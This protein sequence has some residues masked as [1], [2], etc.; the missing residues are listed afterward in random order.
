VTDETSPGIFVLAGPNGGGKS[1]VGGELVRASGGQFFNPDLAALMLREADP[2]LS[3]EEANSLAWREMV[4]LLQVAIDENRSFVFETTL[5][6]STIPQLLWDAAASGIEVRI[7]FVAL[8]SAELHVERV[9]QRVLG[10]GHDI[11]ELRIRDRYD[12]SR[13]HLTDLL[14]VVKEVR[15]FDNSKPR[16]QGYEV[17]EPTMLLHM[18]DR[19]IVWAVALP[20]V[21]DWARPILTAAFE[22][23]AETAGL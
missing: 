2:E 21:P 3:E 13:V 19:Q 14:Q 12:S 11:P 1:S 22:V 17:A 10:G 15:V 23:H 8:A 5:G 7:W 6:G 4:R 20:E 16:P 18:L 9:R